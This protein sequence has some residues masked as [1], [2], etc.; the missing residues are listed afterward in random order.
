MYVLR[1]VQYPLGPR[2]I[3]VSHSQLLVLL[4][5]GFSSVLIEV[6]PRESVQTYSRRRTVRELERKRLMFG[7][8]VDSCTAQGPAPD[9]RFY[10]RAAVLGTSWIFFLKFGTSDQ[11]K[12]NSSSSAGEKKTGID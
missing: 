10:S 3:Q 12:K 2:S 11:K 7:Q 6:T 9:N 8:R 4:P 1:T 5:V